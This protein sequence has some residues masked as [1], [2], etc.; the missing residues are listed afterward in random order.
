MRTFRL[1]CVATL[2][3]SFL[4][5]FGVHFIPRL[6]FKPQ[7]IS[8]FAGKWEYFLPPN[9]PST[10]GPT[11]NNRIWKMI[12]IPGELPRTEK[13][14]FHG[15]V[16]YRFQFK[17]PTKCLHNSCSFLFGE[18]GDA[19]RLYLNGNEVASRGA[20]PPHAEYEKHYPFQSDVPPILFR[21]ADEI[22]QLELLVYSF[23]FQQTGPRKAPLG[24]ALTQDA[25]AYIKGAMFQTIF[26]PFAAA[27][28][29]LLLIVFSLLFPLSGIKKTS[30][31][32]AFLLYCLTSALFLLS[33]TEIPREFI[34]LTAVIPLHFFFR[35]L[36]D[37]MFFEMV[38]NY[39]NLKGRWIVA[40]NAFYSVCILPFLILATIGSISLWLQ[41]R[42]ILPIDSVGLTYELTRYSWGMK[43]LPFVAAFLGAV[44]LTKLRHRILALSSL[45]VLLA[46]Q[47]S[48]I[49]LFF[50]KIQ[51][52]YYIKFYPLFV[53]FA[54]AALLIR[55]SAKVILAEKV[56]MAEEVSR[57]RLAGQVSHDIRSPLSAIAAVEEDL[58][59]LPEETRTIIRGALTRIKDITNILGESS[60]QF[61][62]KANTNTQIQGGESYL[63][64]G[65]VEIIMSE[66]RAEYRSRTGLE[67]ITRL[68]PQSYDLFAAID[69]KEFKRVLSNLINNGV[70]ALSAPGRIEVSLSH[71]DDFA[72][73][74][75]SDKGNGI[76]KDRIEKLCTRGASFDKPGGQGLGLSHAKEAVNSWGGQ[77]EIISTEGKGTNV[78]LI[79][80]KCET[81]GWFLSK[82]IISKGC[83]IAVLDDDS[84]IHAVWDNRIA[85]DHA[86]IVHYS[87]AAEFRAGII[88]AG[89]TGFDLFLVDYE[90]LGDTVSGLDLIQNFN[91]GSRCV[92]V[93]SHFEKEGIRKRCAD[94]GVKLLPK[95][96][97]GFVPIVYSAC[98]AETSADLFEGALFEAVLLDNDPLIR[99]SWANRAR[100]NKIKL[101][102]FS[103][104][105]E[106]FSALPSL[107]LRTAI[108]VDYDLRS[109]VNGAEV[110]RKLSGLGFQETFV[111]TGYRTTEIEPMPWV[112]AV[113]GKEPP[114]PRG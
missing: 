27:V 14:A 16:N 90:L 68:D 11:T 42:Q 80:P 64:S 112:R 8:N 49:L 63:L 97:A 62:S 110:T 44:Q 59:Y 23:K 36:S 46:M 12:Q 51:G 60:Q 79:L 75:V 109:E 114:W 91:L 35:Y 82:L 105:K 95:G 88:A 43:L 106:L 40:V 7:L 45:S 66:K 53:G 101:L 77:I 100:K 28:G 33:F 26:L 30:L 18:I 31:Y 108:Y 37:W 70:E 73:I 78:R 98:P 41:A 103:K 55:R 65:L 20:F 2:G 87:S 6:N 92:L 74:S 3:A 94:L 72:V 56:K 21:G 50:G 54:F 19:V 38:R 52:N 107:G 5:S 89:E 9:E 15:W 39:F 48:D 22:N 102:T 29:L 32:S 83:R 34:P 61:D 13:A 1:V 86:R 99:E 81:P 24:L 67:L 104:P 47:I 57:G 58:R 85:S 69:P 84:S 111:T 71:E 17:T 113:I 96:L 10:H 4:I 93:T 76:P 25:R